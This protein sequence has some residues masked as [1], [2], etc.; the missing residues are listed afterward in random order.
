[1]SSSTNEQ[2]NDQKALLAALSHVSHEIRTPLNAILGFTDLLKDP[3]LNAEDRAQFLSVITRS[4]KSLMR[5]I[6]DIL[7]LSKVES[8]HLQ[9][10][11][12]SFSLVDVLSEVIDL[13]Q[14]KVKAKGVSIE[15]FMDDSIS[16]RISSDP[17]RIRQI[18]TNIIGNA[19]K[20]TEKGTI[21]VQVSSEIRANDHLGVSITV[22]DTG[23]GF[24]EEKREHLFIPFTQADQGITRKFGGTGLGLALS[25]KLARALKGDV[26]VKDSSVGKGSTFL[27]QFEVPLVK[28]IPIEK[29]PKQTSASAAGA[30]PQ[31]RL[32]GIRVLVADDSP[33]NQYIVERLLSV[34]GAKVDLANNGSEALDK[35]LNGNYDLIL[36]DIQMPEVDGY[37]ATRRLRA[38]GFRKPVIALTAHA[39]LEERIK[40]LEAGCDFHLTKPLN[41][42]ALVNTVEEYTSRH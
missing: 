42:D 12:T 10:E 36:M 1:M 7:D 4:G 30:K 19:V 38:S 28:D 9:F 6:D 20:F 18:L 21:S 29:L 32:S 34:N 33:D 23:V 17:M 27:I 2:N 3:S 39:L 24:S 22:S 26:S 40:T 25:R 37:E 5:I 15:L 13:F 16:Q 11:N 41:F 14:E 31:F 35:A 8:G